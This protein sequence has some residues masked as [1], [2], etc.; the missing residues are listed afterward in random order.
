[1]WI[2]IGY[3]RRNVYRF[4]WMYRFLGVFLI[5]GKVSK[6][7]FKYLYFVINNLLCETKVC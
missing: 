2:L 1:M 3:W 4:G 7:S 5:L 6:S